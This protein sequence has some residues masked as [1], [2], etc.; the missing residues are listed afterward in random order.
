MPNNIKDIKNEVYKL[1]NFKNILIAYLNKNPIINFKTFNKYE[2]EYFI[3]NKFP[4]N[5]K[6]NI[7]KNYFYSSKSSNILFKW[8]ENDK[9]IKGNAFM[10]NTFSNH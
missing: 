4:F 8:F 1:S 5:L 2:K 7:I 6:E 3:E 9:T 10:Q